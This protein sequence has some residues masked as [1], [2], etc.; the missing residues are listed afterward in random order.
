MKTKFFAT[1]LG[2]FLL[3][4]MS[5]AAQ[6]IDETFPRQSVFLEIG[7]ASNGVGLNYE[8]R[9]KNPKWGWRVGAA[10]GFAASS[11]SIFDFSSSERI[12]SGSLGMNYLLGQR[13]SKLDI[14]G[15]ISMGVHHYHAKYH[16]ESSKENR[17]AYY[18]Y[19]SAGWRY[20]ARSGFQFRLG[21]SPIFSFGG[22]YGYDSKLF[23][24]YLSIGYAF[25]GS[26]K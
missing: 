19:A 14:G 23:C 6:Q 5:V 9:L 18:F 22:K 11:S 17:F 21:L 8:R 16:G 13:R 26:R 20:Q 12:Y 15:G 7:G 25:G 3:N 4:C 2:L 1:F 24:P 10:W